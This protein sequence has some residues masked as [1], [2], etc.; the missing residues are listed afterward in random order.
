MYLINALIFIGGLLLLVKGA[1]LFVMSS[2]WIAKRFGVSEFII[3]LTLVSIGTSMPELASSLTASFEHASGIVM[4][5]VLGSN[6]ANIGLVV[7]TAALLSNVKTEELMLRRDGYIM[8]F[9]AFLFLLFVLDFRISRI[10]ASIFLFLYVAYLLFLLEKVKKH[11]EDIYFKD[12]I[13]YFF[14]FEYIFDLKARIETGIRGRIDEKRIKEAIK[15][16]YEETERETKTEEVI[17]A[18]NKT[19]TDIKAENE[20]EIKN[21]T[22][23]ENETEYLF[24]SS[25]LIEFIKLVTSGFA[26]IIGAKY[27]IEQ[28][29]F[30]AQ[31][32]EVPETLIGVSL[33][34]IGTSL[35][36]LMVTVSAAR[37]GYA[38]IALGNVI[39]SNI[40]NTLLILGC[41]GLVHPLTVTEI[42]VYYITPFMLLISLLLLLF[43][44]TGW[45]IKRFEGLILFLLYSG[46]MF[47]IFRLG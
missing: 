11:E 2:S 31:I 8:L 28:S 40:T 36:E 25:L 35:P 18:E 1:D 20:T 22:E 21:E 43:I 6:I 42:S 7:S 13:H 47:F 24:E 41:S 17:R 10:E 16:S 5:D 38:S 29:I 44:R 9:S 15:E 30:F 39:G 12:F 4:G 32:L 27:F 45:R 33:V 34:A 23:I 26:I 37:S 3:G 14:K 46:F 19:C